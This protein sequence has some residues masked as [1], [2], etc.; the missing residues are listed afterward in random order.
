MFF[1]AHAIT[2]SA[3]ALDCQQTAPTTMDGARIYAIGHVWSGTRVGFGAAASRG[4]VWVAYYNAER[5]LTVAE[6]AHDRQKL[7]TITLESIFH[8]W[9]S[10]NVTVVGIAPDG[11]RHVAGNM[12]ASKLVYART[13]SSGD[14]ATLAF[15]S[16]IGR[17]ETHVTYP[18]FFNGADGTLYFMYRSGE[19]G[20]GEWLLNR[21]ADGSWTHAGKLFSNMGRDGRVSAYPSS[22]VR[23]PDGTYHVAIVWRRTSDVRTN[24]EVSYAKTRDFT[25]WAGAFTPFVAGSLRNE[26]AERIEA[27]GEDSGLLNSAQV[28]LS[29]AGKP[30]VFYTRYSADGRNNLVAATPLNEGWFVHE[31]ARAAQRKTLAGGGSLAEAPRFSVA[32]DGDKLMIRLSFSG[33]PQ[34]A[35]AVDAQTLVKFSAA[36]AM[37][38]DRTPKVTRPVTYGLDDP[39]SVSQTVLDYQRPGQ[40]VGKF[41]WTAQGPNRDRP[42]ACR[43]AAPLACNPP[44]TPL[45]FS[46]STAAGKQ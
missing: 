37:P 34:Q 43:P 9:D 27:P 28:A 35:F 17:E 32:P 44:P 5:K 29:E 3:A 12:H 6:L 24:F 15:R 39:V 38:D 11:S 18:R 1:G 2:F 33:E 16:M 23:G 25:G 46:E 20:D 7:C 31:L 26:L 21:W 36:M 19:S 22:L 8:G 14:L 45:L 42:R 40:P 13:D 41:V 4:T 10:H 30:I